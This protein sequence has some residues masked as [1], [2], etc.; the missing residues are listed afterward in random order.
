MT[1]K[2]DLE[3]KEVGIWLKNNA[4]KFSVIMSR[5]P[6]AAFY[7]GNLIASIPEDSYK[8]VT[9]Y[10]KKRKAD[11]L[12]IDERNIPTRRPKLKFLLNAY[13]LPK[14]LEM[15]YQREYEGKRQ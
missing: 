3:H 15:V 6:Y 13:S 10:A 11:Y 4:E 7:S 5:K 14:E 12:V 9:I 1:K 2:Y 8:E